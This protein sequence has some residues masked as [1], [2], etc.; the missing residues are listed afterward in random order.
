MSEKL[1]RKIRSH[2][3]KLKVKMPKYPK[4]EKKAQGVLNLSE[5]ELDSVIKGNMI[6]I[7]A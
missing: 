3:N 4:T 5:D 1:V 2:S 7:T 6:D